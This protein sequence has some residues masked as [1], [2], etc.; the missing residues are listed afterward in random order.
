MRDRNVICP[1]CGYECEKYVTADMICPNTNCRLYGEPIS[2]CL[3]NQ[4]HDLSDFIRDLARENHAMQERLKESGLEVL[5]SPLENPN[6]YLLRIGA[7][8]M[9]D[10]SDI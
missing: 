5:K 9:Q 4:L 7:A 10:K 1:V 6:E 8:A 3:W 2:P